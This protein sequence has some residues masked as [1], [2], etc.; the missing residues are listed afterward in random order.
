MVI[1]GD[2][3][4]S[5]ATVSPGILY[6]DALETVSGNGTN[7]T[8]S[9][10]VASKTSGAWAGLVFNYQDDSNYYAARF[11]SDAAGFQMIKVVGGVV[12]VM[13]YGNTSANFVEDVFYTMTITSDTAYVFDI[14]ITKAGQ[15]AVFGSGTDRTDTESN[16]TGGYAGVYANSTGYS[17]GHDNFSLEVIPEPATMGLV[18]MFAVGLIFVRRHFML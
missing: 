2:Y 6:N 3:L 11:K 16:F 4:H 9:L 13:Q 10:D 1:S 5:H 8:L 17:A 12:G 7:F 14:T 15:S 18:G